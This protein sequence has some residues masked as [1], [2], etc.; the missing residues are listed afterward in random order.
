[1]SV[2]LMKEFAVNRGSLVGKDGQTLLVGNSD[3]V[4]IDGALHSSNASNG[5]SLQV[6]PQ[7]P[8]IN[9][10]LPNSAPRR[11]TNGGNATEDDSV[12]VEMYL[13][14][15]ADFNRAIA[16]FKS[17]TVGLSI[18]L[19]S[20]HISVTVDSLH[21]HKKGLEMTGSAVGGKLKWTSQ[22]NE[23]EDKCD[24]RV[25]RLD[26]DK[27]KAETVQPVVE[28]LHTNDSARLLKER[29]SRQL[30]ENCGGGN[31]HWGNHPRCG[32]CRTRSWKVPEMQQLCVD[33]AMIDKWGAQ[34]YI[35]NTFDL[36]WYTGPRFAGFSNFD[37][38]PLDGQGVVYCRH[39]CGPASQYT[40]RGQFGGR[41]CSGKVTWR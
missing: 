5:M 18:P 34:W 21:K 36:C 19:G 13:V 41:K 11:L 23:G 26:A 28:R 38:A 17:G 27:L 25:V 40:Y 39:N 2:S 35:Q 31:P 22:C 12:E 15:R 6:V 29:A 32:T 16:V 30:V 20:D 7:Q 4:V 1:L 37:A 10:V 9:N 33:A 8:V 3:F 24:I 14:P